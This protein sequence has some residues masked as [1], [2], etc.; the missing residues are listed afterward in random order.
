M[1]QPV[2]AQDFVHVAWATSV[3]VLCHTVHRLLSTVTRSDLL[4]ARP[5]QWFNDGV[6]NDFTRLLNI[7]RCRL[8]ADGFS[9]PNVL[10]RN[11]FFHA[12]LTADAK[13]Q[14][15]IVYATVKNRGTTKRPLRNAGC[16]RCT[17]QQN[18]LVFPVHVGSCHWI[19][20]LL[21]FRSCENSC[22]DALGVGIAYMSQ[23]FQC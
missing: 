8:E 21:G 19:C 11:C 20:I 3:H 22:F 4:T 9:V 7:W 6:I 13:S 23:A 18:L 17:L 16:N 10:Y 5:T 14:P 12:S 15:G 1:P 2:D